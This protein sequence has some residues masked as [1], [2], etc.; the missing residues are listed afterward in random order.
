MLLLIL[1]Y[2]LSKQPYISAFGSKAPLHPNTGCGENLQGKSAYSSTSKKHYYY[3]HK[4]TCPKG[5]LNRIDAEIVHMLVFDWLKDISANGERFMRLQEQ[6]KVRLRKELTLLHTEHANLG[7]RAEDINSQIKARIREF[8]KTESE[9]VRKTIEQSIEKLSEQKP[10]IK[11]KRAYVEH[12][13]SDLQE[14]INDSR[15]LFKT[16]SESIREALYKFQIKSASPKAKVLLQSL[17]AVLCLHPTH[18]KT[19]LSG[20]NRKGLGS[21]MFAPAPPDRLELPT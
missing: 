19:A 9:I 16:Y 2:T 15:D 1:K 10:E 7:D 4:S 14:L 5:G 3:S 8:T 18:I 11:D 20:V 6:G 13:V 12:T 17:F 21:S